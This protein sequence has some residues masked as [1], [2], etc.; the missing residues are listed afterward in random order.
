M[1]DFERYTDINKTYESRILKGFLLLYLMTSILTIFINFRL[2]LGP[3]T[4]LGDFD[5]FTPGWFKGIGYSLSLTLFLKIFAA[6]AAAF[7]FKV[8]R[9]IPRLLD[10]GC[11]G[12][13]SK[14]KKKIH[15]DY[16]ALYTN[17][18]FNLD[19]CYT[20]VINIV[21]VCMTLSPLLPFV[22]YIAVVYLI[23][24]YWRDKYMRKTLLP[25]TDQL[26]GS[27]E[28]Q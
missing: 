18:D 23:V 4:Y 19:F 13:M 14:T 11:S 6:I 28:F 22:F 16:E 9:V 20:E 12:D 21:F 7:V 3:S 17:N 5:D 25:S 26:Q 24:V 8:L 2:R 27:T 10:R 1:S 15:S